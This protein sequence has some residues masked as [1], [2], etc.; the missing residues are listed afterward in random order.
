MSSLLDPVCSQ[1]KNL[2]EVQHKSSK[3]IK[4][5]E[6]TRTQFF[7]CHV[8]GETQQGDGNGK[9]SVSMATGRMTDSRGATYGS[10]PR[11]GPVKIGEFCSLVQVLLG[12]LF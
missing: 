2:N 5:T 8:K 9:Y 1:N 4:V 6:G 7:Y 12:L 11:S 3:L 10:Q